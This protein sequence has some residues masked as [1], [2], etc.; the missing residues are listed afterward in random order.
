MAVIIDGSNTPTAGGIGYG[1]GTELAFSAAGTAGEVLTSAG[2]GTPTWSIG[3]VTLLANS[4]AP[5]YTGGAYTW[6]IT[7]YDSAS[8]Y[9]VT[10]TNGTVS[11]ASGTVTYTPSTGGAGGFVING[12]TIS[13]TVTAFPTIAGGT[14]AVFTSGQIA[15]ILS[16]AKLT[17]TTAVI[18]YN[19][20]TNN[21]IYAVVAS[22]AGTTVTYGTA[23]VVRSNFS[24]QQA[25]VC[26]LS[27]T[28]CLVGYETTAS[29]HFG[30]K[31]LSISGT[32]ITVN[33]EVTNGIVSTG[34]VMCPLTS[35]T[36]L[37]MY[38]SSLVVISVA[39]TVPSFGTAVSTGLA[40]N[41]KSISQLSSTKA[42]ILYDGTSSY[43]TANVVSVGGTTVT[44][45]SPLVIQSVA[46]G[47]LTSVIALSDTTAVAEVTGA[48]SIL[49]LVPL[50]I[51]GTTVT[52]GSISSLTAANANSAPQAAAYISGSTAVGLYPET[53]SG[54]GVA[55]VAIY[56]SS[57]L[58]TGSV[59]T[60][61]AGTTIGRMTGV[62]LDT[63]KVFCV[64][65]TSTTSASG[66]VLTVS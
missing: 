20:Y 52:A 36:A 4:A 59:T 30:A 57:T 18:L 28:L 42:I 48:S 13:V 33:A 32:T 25:S 63:N 40:A 43:P 50:T 39:G 37:A 31:T 24:P 38:Y 44:I 12:R 41:Y 21:N 10:T 26:A 14:S 9:T 27:S 29:N 17:T 66:C 16:V 46:T 45:G 54:A 5:Y 51:S 34:I 19:S 65:N 6:T 49:Q 22:I 11:Q 53:S 3:T 7:N 1:D 15:G 61:V 58:A 64:F 60:V 23:V 8:T 62:Y 47:Q 55:V 2:V 35:T 56:G